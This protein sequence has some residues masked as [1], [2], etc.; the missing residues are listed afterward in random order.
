MK[1]NVRIAIRLPGTLLRL[2]DAAAGRTE[3]DGYSARSRW[4]R[5]ALRRQLEREGARKKEQAK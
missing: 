4:I 5:N 1:N 2:V 3:E